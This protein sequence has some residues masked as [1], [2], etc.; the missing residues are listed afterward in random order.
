MPIHL[1]PSDRAH[2]DNPVKIALHDIHWQ[3]IGEDDPRHRLLAHVDIGGASHHLEA[4]EF[5][6][7]GDGLA[8]VEYPED[9]E[10]LAEITDSWPAA[11]V[12]IEGR[13]YGLFM[14]PYA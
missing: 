14:T 7:D 3:A 4:R 6:E 13:T 11:F 1:D 12:E 10:G 5:V 2:F 9:W 8:P